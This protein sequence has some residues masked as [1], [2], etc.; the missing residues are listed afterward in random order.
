MHLLSTYELSDKDLMVSNDKLIHRD[1][2]MPSTV[3]RAELSHTHLST[4]SLSSGI[5]QKYHYPH[6]SGKSND[7]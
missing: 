4:N 6:F 3:L 1:F 7:V 5:K 2:D